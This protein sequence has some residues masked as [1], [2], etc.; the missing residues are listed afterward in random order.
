MLKEKTY[1]M[2]F[3][4]FQK[5]Y[6]NNISERFYPDK[7]GNVRFIFNGYDYDPFNQDGSLAKVLYQFPVYEGHH[8]TPENIH[9]FL[10]GGFP[11]NV[12][13]INEEYP[14]PAVSF[15]DRLKHDLRL[16]ILVSKNN[17]FTAKLRDVFTNVPVHHTTARESHEWLA[18][19]NMRYW[20]Q[21]L[22]F[23]VWCAT[24]G[25]GIGLD[26]LDNPIFMFHLHFTVRRILY[27]LNYI[28]PGDTMFD[29]KNGQ[30][31]KVA[32]QRLR[33]EFGISK[34]A[35]F[36]FTHGY[37]NGL[38]YIWGYWGIGG[39][40]LTD[41]EVHSLRLLWDTGYH[42]VTSDEGTFFEPN[43]TSTK[44]V[45]NGPLFK[46]EG[47]VY[48][49]S[50]PLIN[51]IY[52]DEATTQYLNF[53]PRKGNGLTKAGLGRINRSIEA[54]VYCILGAQMNT[55]NPIVGNS[56]ATQ[57]TQQEFLTLFEA[58]IIENDIS[59]SIQRY[60]FAIQQAK[61]KLDYALA[62]SCWLLPSNM[63]INTQSVVGY[64]NK[65]QRAT[66][67]MKFGINDSL[68][69]EMKSVGIKHNMGHSKVVLPHRPVIQSSAKGSEAS[70]LSAAKPKPDVKTQRVTTD[71]HGINL[72]MITASAAGLAWYLFR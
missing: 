36:R 63:I 24:S 4:E 61:V 55:R 71:R 48:G 58:A 54:Y 42:T 57:E 26:L 13:L 11:R 22:N 18:G 39:H 68:N 35:D 7:N 29:S 6:P 43:K 16:K 65:L 2:K 8:Y 32:L 14:I 62:P 49:G 53:I 5:K 72:V 31:S 69:A 12:M 10:G 56:G 1:K 20:P 59:K 66:N 34:D 47:G 44:K 21:A 60:Q 38:G 19:P 30:Y 46:D 15:D 41:S 25:C 40:E 70:S 17:A 45:R 23:A 50:N 51:Y 67:D 27:E 33:A 3:T 64:N 52:N 37:N 28:L 9:D